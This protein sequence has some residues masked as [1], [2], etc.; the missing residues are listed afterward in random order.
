[1]I[2]HSFLYI[3]ASSKALYSDIYV[4]SRESFILSHNTLHLYAIREI[5][6]SIESVSVVHAKCISIQLPFRWLDIFIEAWLK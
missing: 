6:S 2:H 3:N 5:V 1:M 4:G